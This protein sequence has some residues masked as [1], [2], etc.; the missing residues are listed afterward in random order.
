MD[1]AVVSS[2]FLQSAG[3]GR[4]RGGH[5]NRL[6]FCLSGNYRVPVNED[7]EIERELVRR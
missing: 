6:S 5:W 1:Y 3:V 2:A 7:Y 4:G